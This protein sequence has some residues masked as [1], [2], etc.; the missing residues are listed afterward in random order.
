MIEQEQM[1]ITFDQS[2]PSQ[3]KNSN[4]ESKD[5]IN[6]TIIKQKMRTNL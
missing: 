1:L 5:T 2:E 3:M 4:E 6:E